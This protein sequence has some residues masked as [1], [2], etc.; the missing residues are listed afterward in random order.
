MKLASFEIASTPSYGVVVDGGIVDLGQRLPLAPD[1]ATLLATGLETAREFTAARPDHTFA[2]LSWSPVIPAPGAIYCIGLN[3]RAHVEE[4]GRPLGDWPTVFIRVAGSQI[5]H[6]APIIRPRVSRELDFEGE[7]ALIIGQG[8][9][10]IDRANALDHI[11]GYS[12][13]NDASIRDFQRHSGQYTA[14]KNF[15]ATGAF[16]PWLVTS[17]EIGDPAALE[18]TTR[19]NGEVVQHASLSELLFTIP[20]LVSY[21]SS[22]IVLRPGDVIVTGTPA[23]VGSSRE[24][25]LWMKPGDTVEVTVP[26][27]GTLANPVTDE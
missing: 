15:P 24:P 14:G 9:R 25:K 17:D 2:E 22:F 5:G 6:L 4:V 27:I 18:L 1:I 13:Y 10:Y 21:I 20:E 11:A 8:G 3:Y 19:L 23:G 16:G 7:L 12:L 26:G